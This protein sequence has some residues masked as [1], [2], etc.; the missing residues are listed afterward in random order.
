MGGPRHR[1]HPQASVLHAHRVRLFI[2]TRDGHDE[3]R[4]GHGCVS[5][6]AM[7][8]PT[9]A[10]PRRHGRRTHEANPS[11]LLPGQLITIDRSIR[12]LRKCECVRDRSLSSRLSSVHN[13]HT[14]DFALKVTYLSYCSTS[15]G[16][17]FGIS[18]FLPP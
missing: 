2:H 8:S 9:R 12:E 1:S 15:G 3:C 11:I 6:T 13:T 17:G 18:T 4:S 5:S 10:D 7:G 14:L 16:L